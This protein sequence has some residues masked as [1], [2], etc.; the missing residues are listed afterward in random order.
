M[1]GVQPGAAALCSPRFSPPFSLPLYSYLALLLCLAAGLGFG[2]CAAQAPEAAAL[3]E[4]LQTDLDRAH[5]AQGN[6][7][8]LL[9][10][11]DGGA[12]QLAAR[13]SV[14]MNPAS[15][16]KLLTTYAALATLG[17]DY[18]WH[19][20]VFVS[21]APKGG[22][23]QGDLIVRGDG[24]PSLVIERWWLLV[25]RVRALGIKD[26]E[27]D[28]VLD[29]SRYGPAVDA[30]PSLDHNDLRPYNVAPDALL[31]NF[32][33]LS[34]DF[35][36]DPDAGIARVVATPQLDGVSVPS[37][38]PLVGGPCGD[39]KGHLKA[40][41]SAPKAPRFQGVYS[42]ACGL[43]SWHV[44]QL[45]PDEYALA[46]FR[47][48]WRQAGG[49]FHG[50]VRSGRVDAAAILLADQE[51]APLA[52]VIRDINKNS[53][54][55][56]A[57]QLFLT[58]G[59]AGSPATRTGP[60]P[61]ASRSQADIN[62]VPAADAAAPIPAA[63]VAAAPD[64]AAALP[65]LAAEQTAPPADAQPE[66][67]ARSIE[68]V[69]NWLAQ[70]GLAMPELVLQNGSGLSRQE[71]ISAASLARLL[72]HAWNSTDMPN[73]LASLSL[74][75]VDG[76]MKHRKGAVHAAYLKTGYLSEVRALAGYVF[77][78]SGHRYVIVS[79][80]NDPHADAAQEALDNLLQWV[81]QRG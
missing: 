49:S 15:T 43:K 80:V 12:L 58:L 69:R 22:R 23:L 75:G 10:P 36:P 53:N 3:P 78:A 18:R 28:L 31:I 73:F 11:L 6:T 29:R 47:T 67:P 2:P 55:V 33:T 59:G 24:D 48:L 68:F 57:R 60:E 20:S 17:P 16:M 9:V 21:R 32:K 25:Q 62:A 66:A 37:H 39:W 42:A 44:S 77:A 1:P 45:S 74:A 4:A 52:E 51:S 40:D 27:G 71:R 70:Q 76:T 65:E 38:V 81:W 26:I 56:M 79:F 64:N 41:F 46:T 63:T 7:A 35:V 30:G 8:F 72:V 5:V 50:T 19:T 61:A 34:L 13:A 14:P 54:N